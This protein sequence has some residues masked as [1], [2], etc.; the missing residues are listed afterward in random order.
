MHK[1]S[2][3]FLT[4]AIFFYVPTKILKFWAEIVIPL[5]TIK[6]RGGLVPVKTTK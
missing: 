5:W 4:V 1:F 3:I 2:Y 6:W